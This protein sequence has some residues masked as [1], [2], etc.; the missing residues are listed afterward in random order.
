[1]MLPYNRTIMF[2]PGTTDC[3]NNKPST[4][5]RIDLFKLLLSVVLQTQ[6]R[7]LKAMLLTTLQD[8][9]IRPCLLLYIAHIGKRICFLNG[10]GP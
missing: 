5:L 8:L 4:S 6:S 3:E 9:L 7:I 2:L 1:M 10:Y